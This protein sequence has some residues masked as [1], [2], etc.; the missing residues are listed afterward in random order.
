MRL[1]IISIWI[2][3]KFPA[4]A[5]KAGNIFTEP[6]PLLNDIDLP[7]FEYAGLIIG[8]GSIQSHIGEVVALTPKVDAISSLVIPRYG[9]RVGPIFLNTTKALP[10][11]KILRTVFIQ[12]FP[13]EINFYFLFSKTPSKINFYSTDISYSCPILRTLQF[14]LYR[15]CYCSTVNTIEKSRWIWLS[16]IVKEIKKLDSQSIFAEDNSADAKDSNGN[17][18]VGG[19]ARLQPRGSDHLQHGS[20]VSYTPW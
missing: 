3:S 8:T 12:N 10:F 2:I 19:N 17:E 13:A 14:T 16:K 15:I 9:S 1:W 18:D 7:G 4:D 5:G 11:R 20:S 6:F